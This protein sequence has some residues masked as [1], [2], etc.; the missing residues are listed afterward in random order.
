MARY[1]V[2][3]VRSSTAEV[4]IADTVNVSEAGALVFRRNVGHYQTGAVK[5]EL[6][7]AFA[8]GYWEEVSLNNLPGQ[9]D[10]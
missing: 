5:T 3:K 10:T 7:Q 4:V 9:Q 2:E 1:L 8:P 6:I